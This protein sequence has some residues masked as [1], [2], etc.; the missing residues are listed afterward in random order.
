MNITMVSVFSR[1]SG[2]PNLFGTTMIKVE[3]L[4]KKFGGVAAVDNISFNVEKQEIVGFLGPNA[5]GKTT[6]MR[7][8][9]SYIGPTSGKATIAGFDVVRNSL[10]ARKL[11]GYLPESV[12][13]YPEMRVR[14]YLSFRAKLKGMPAHERKSRI[15]EVLERCRVK[16]VEHKIIAHL[17]KGYRQRVGLAEAIIHNPPILILDEPTIGLDPHQIKQTR[18]LI[19]ELG[20]N[21]TIIL[22]THILPEVEMLCDRVIIIHQGRIAAMDTLANLIKEQKLKLEIRGH[23]I[24]RAAAAD[25]IA[26]IENALKQIEGVKSVSSVPGDPWHIVTIELATDKDIREDV[27]QK[28]MQNQWVLREFRTERTT[29]EDRFIGITA[30]E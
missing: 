30:K 28:I 3:G 4:T 16:D 24:G 17:S 5:A 23:A 13:F 1:R 25:T 10:E 22:S 20:K 27:Y 29:L 15:P 11:I 9:T 12:P 19:K 2:I 6:T 7:I 18:E 8:L 26:E 14:E 21:H